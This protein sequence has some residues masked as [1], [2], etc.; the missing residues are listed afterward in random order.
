MSQDIP[1][2]NTQ[3]QGLNSL[4]NW[5]MA[6]L[7]VGR[8]HLSELCKTKGLL[9]CVYKDHREERKQRDAVD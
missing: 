4:W 2:Y 1:C 6:I 8:R 3:G 9:K 5:I 7:N